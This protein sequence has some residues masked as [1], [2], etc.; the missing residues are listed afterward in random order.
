MMNFPGFVEEGGGGASGRKKRE[1]DLGWSRTSE[2]E[3]RGVWREG[4]EDG[5]ETEDVC[6][7]VHQNY[8]KKMLSNL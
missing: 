3:G 6:Y 5:E 4:E 7:E 8:N 2:R 1:R